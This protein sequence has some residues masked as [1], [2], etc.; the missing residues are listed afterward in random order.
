MRLESVVGVDEPD[1]R[2]G[3]TP[4]MDFNSDKDQVE[5]SLCPTLLVC[6]ASLND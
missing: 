1:L 2:A 3:L 6:P 5:N 4:L